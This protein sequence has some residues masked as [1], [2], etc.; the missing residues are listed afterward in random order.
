MHEVNIFLGWWDMVGLVKFN[1]GN[2][3]RIQIYGGGE[4]HRSNMLMENNFSYMWNSLKAYIF[5]QRR[6]NQN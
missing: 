3:M 4:F 2:Q 5:L 6:S 1:D